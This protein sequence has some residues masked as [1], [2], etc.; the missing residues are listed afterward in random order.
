MAFR[1]VT[2]RLNFRTAI[3]C[4]VPPETFLTNAA[5]YLVFD[6]GAVREQAFVLGLMNSLP[7]DWQTR[8][9]LERHLNIY[10]LNALRFPVPTAVDIDAVAERAARLSCVDER[11][12]DFASACGVAC[13][14]VEVDERLRL[15]SE[16][17]AMVA[18]AYGLSNGDLEVVFSD[19]ADAAVPTLYRDL[20]RAAFDAMSP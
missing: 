1:D 14:P 9:M 18:Q 5:P 7:F 11:F 6:M 20:V 13:G 17:D 15:T 2:N 4:L 3:A 10:V 19:F 8:R 16:I 12:G